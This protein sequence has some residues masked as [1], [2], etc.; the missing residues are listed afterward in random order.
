MEYAKK[1][2]TAA[3]PQAR[4][5]GSRIPGSTGCLEVIINGRKAHSK[6]G[7]DGYLNENNSLAMIQKVKAIVEGSV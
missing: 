6:S 1:L 5:T 7:G 4:V 3:Y 2:I